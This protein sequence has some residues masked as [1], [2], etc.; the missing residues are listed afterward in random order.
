MIDF[1]KDAAIGVQL[2]R[3]GFAIVDAVS[4][5]QIDAFYSIYKMF[6]EQID[7]TATNGIHMT[8]WIADRIT[9]LEIKDQI[10]TQ[11]EPITDQL[12][13]N[14]KSNNQVLIVKN[15][16]KVSNF[17]LHQDWSFVD[18]SKFRSVNVWIPLQDTNV[19]NGGLYVIKGSHHLKNDIRGAGALS[20]DFNKYAKSLLKYAVPVDLKRGQ[21]VL[22]FHSTIH[23]SGANKSKSPRIIAAASVTN[24]A[25]IPLI[26]YYD[27]ENSV[28]KQIKVHPDFMFEY[29][30]IRKESISSVPKGE[31]INTVSNYQPQ[32]I[33]LDQI[34]KVLKNSPSEHLTF[35]E[36]L[37]HWLWRTRLR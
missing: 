19:G 20:F 17:P 21:L 14:Y 16:H 27:Q 36:K 6:Q 31:I 1:V 15:Q 33:A 23:G 34:Q 28:L 7:L 12:F 30:D 3:D 26:N 10:T 13:C 32:Q 5:K 9:K 37:K 8:N 11:L 25:A 35:S 2:E 4:E 22:F 29:D 24:N 18:E